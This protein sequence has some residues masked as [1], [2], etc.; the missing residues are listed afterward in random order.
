MNKIK[1][2]VLFI[3][4]VF[5]S[6]CLH[7]L[8]G[9]SI[10]NGSE[11]IKIVNNSELELYNQMILETPSYYPYP[12]N[13]TDFIPSKG[14]HS[15]KADFRKYLKNKMCYIWLFDKKVLDSL[16]WKEVTEKNLYVKRYDLSLQDLE[17]MNWTIIF[18]NEKNIE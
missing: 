11:E 2:I 3:C 14:S 1:I 13:E 4:T 7:E 9:E 17:E 18:N 8:L 5:L 12:P 15:T 6:S 10:D 16:S